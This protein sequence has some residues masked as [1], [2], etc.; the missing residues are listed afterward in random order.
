MEDLLKS[1]EEHIKW[2]KHVSQGKPFPLVR[3]FP[4]FKGRIDKIVSLNH[5]SPKSSVKFLG[6]D[7]ISCGGTKL[8]TFCFTKEPENY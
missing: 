1:M 6:E 4:Q 2:R 7:C 8:G 3:G 5:A